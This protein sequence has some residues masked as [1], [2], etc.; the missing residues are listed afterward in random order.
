MPLRYEQLNQMEREFIAINLRM[1]LSKR[2]VARFLC[3]AAS[4]VSREVNRNCS[5]ELYHSRIAHELASK[6]RQIPRRKRLLDH[7]GRRA[8]ADRLL[9]EYWSPEQ[10]AA[11]NNGIGSKMTLYRMIHLDPFRWRD[12]LRRSNK[13]NHHY[14]RIRNSK[15]IDPRPTVVDR[16]IRLV[17]RQTII[18]G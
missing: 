8:W 17:L 1:G 18:L 7:P 11:R 2:K 10:I 14:E 6:R 13:K 3:R 12:Y 9:Q 4:T 15:S 5:N 16:K